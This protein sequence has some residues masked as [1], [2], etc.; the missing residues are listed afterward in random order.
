MT[1]AA[2]WVAELP[3]HRAYLLRVARAQVHDAAAAE[4]IVQET[5]FAALRSAQAFEARSS[6]RTWLT[7]ILLRRV[8]DHRRRRARSPILLHAD[9]DADR[10]DADEPLGPAGEA[11]DPLH[12]LVARESIEQLAAAVADL[13][14]LPRRVFELRE[15]EGMDNRRAAQRLGIEPARAAV[16]RHRVRATLRQRLGSARP[17]AAS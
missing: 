17:G 15:I 1:A 10:D 6:V 14:E 7:G 16:L 12:Q 11:L 13:P 2:P 3:G 5:L 9:V 4:D 8:L